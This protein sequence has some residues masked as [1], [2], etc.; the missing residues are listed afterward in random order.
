MKGTKNAAAWVKQHA[1]LVQ[2]ISEDKLPLPIGLSWDPFNQEV[3]VQVT[4]SAY[5]AWMEAVLSPVLEA[6]PHEGFTHL[7][8]SG[9]LAR[10]Q[11]VK[12]R[13]VA[14]CRTLGELP[15][16]GAS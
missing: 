13:V 5:R 6:V 1:G 11:M 12:V 15:E 2:V 8:A 4:E 16:V 14:V 9:L 7:Y 10:C 3:T